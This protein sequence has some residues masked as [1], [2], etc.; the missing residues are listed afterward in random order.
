MLRTV[1]WG[2]LFVSLLLITGALLPAGAVGETRS[3]WAATRSEAGIIF[4]NQT[5]TGN[6]VTVR[7]AT[8]PNGGFVVVHGSRYQE[9]PTVAEPL[10]VS[11]YLPPGQHTNI[12]VPVR[13]RPHGLTNQTIERVTAVAHEDTNGDRAFDYYPGREVDGPYTSAGQ[14]VTATALVR[15]RGVKTH[16]PATMMVTQTTNHTSTATRE[17]SIITSR[18]AST[19]TQSVP[20]GDTPGDGAFAA[21]SR[22]G[23]L[24][25]VG[26]GLAAS[27]VVV[28]IGTQWGR[29]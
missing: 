10:G 11:R 6:T 23:G 16:T 25:V 26:T 8:L 20:A 18:P 29:R 24:F 19:A 1:I 12:T 9:G 7:R 4:S 5:T 2:C 15:V 13:S 28:L 27:L 3:D 21:I 17:R 14:P 22:W